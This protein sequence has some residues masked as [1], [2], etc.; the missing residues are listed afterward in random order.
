MTAVTLAKDP[1][2]AGYQCKLSSSE[3]LLKD[4]ATTTTV[5]TPDL[6]TYIKSKIKLH[7]FSTFIQL[8]VNLQEN[9]SVQ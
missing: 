3:D 2:S 6:T 4:D 5:S 7:L 9:E 8:I 1:S